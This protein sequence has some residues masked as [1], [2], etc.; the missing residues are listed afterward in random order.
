MAKDINKYAQNIARARYATPSYRAP[1][2]R[3]TIDPTLFSG[4]KAA[5]GA[6][7]ASRAIEGGP[8]L[9]SPQE[10]NPIIDAESGED[11][12][13]PRVETQQ[14]IENRGSS[15]RYMLQTGGPRLDLSF[16]VPERVNPAFDPNKAIGGENVPYQESK[17]VGG[18]FRRMLG[19]ESNRMNIEAQQ[20]Q[21]AEWRAEAKAEKER[22]AKKE[23]LADEIRLRMEADRTLKKED[24]E[25]TAEQNKAMREFTASQNNLDRTLR[26]GESQADRDTRVALAEKENNAAWRRLEAELGFRKGESAA[27]RA[28]RSGESAADRAFRSGESQADRAARLAESEANR[29]LTAAHYG[30]IREDNA[31]DRALRASE[32]A[33]GRAIEEARLGLQREGQAGDNAYRQGEVQ[34]R[35]RPRFER[36]GDN[37]YQNERGDVFEYSPG[38]MDFKTGKSAPGGFKKIPTQPIPKSVMGG[39]GGAAQVDRATGLPIGGGVLRTGGSA[40][41]MTNATPVVTQPRS[42]TLTD[43]ALN[44]LP[45]GSAIL[46]MPRVMTPERTARLEETKRQQQADRLKQI[47]EMQ[48]FQTRDLGPSMF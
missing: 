45:F 16:L 1:Q 33:A 48:E 43:R 11:P 39:G 47:K 31:A 40:A 13:A 36:L 24:R 10:Y 32:G 3:A 27:D 23:D 26:Q 18:F 42:A 30:L 46:D 17:G 37:V 29:N 19:D 15:A 34:Y 14:P 6:P 21:G 5:A 20:A 4:K 38:M 9:P 7:L 25:F 8:A 44:A 35:Q 2:R 41:A 22:Q 28:F 12:N